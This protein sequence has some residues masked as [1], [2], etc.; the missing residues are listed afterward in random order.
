M[1]KRDSEKHIEFG[2]AKCSVGHY[3]LWCWNME[4]EPGR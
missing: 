2:I 3:S 1:N 4:N